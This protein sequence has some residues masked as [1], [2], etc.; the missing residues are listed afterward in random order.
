MAS[1][2]TA[3]RHMSA[4]II[5]VDRLGRVL[6]QHRDDDPA[7]MFPGHWG[8]TGG[9]A[10]SGETPEETARREVREET[11]LDLERFEP[12]RAYYLTAARGRA[13]K[14]DDRAVYL[15]H[16]PCRTPAEELL[17]GEGRALRFFA[18]DELTDVPIAYNHRD[19]LTD[20]FASP[21]YGAYVSGAAFAHEDADPVEAF[22]RA[23]DAGE[24]WF[25]ALMQAIAV[26]ERP[27]E[28]V[29]GHR[30]EYLVGGEAFDWLLL[31]QR[32]LDAAGERI[33]VDAAAR[34][35]FHAAPPDGDGRAIEDARLQQ[36]IGDAKHRAHLNYVYG[37]TVEEAL[38]YA[39]ELDVAKERA[40]LAVRNRWEDGDEPDPVYQRIY[41][42]TRASLLADFREERG[43]PPRG[44]IALDELREFHYWL[45]KYRVKH[46]EPARVASDTRKAL[47]QLS[48]IEDAARR[49][50]RLSEVGHR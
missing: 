23:L 19:V 11:G 43:A 42:R 8:I 24:P 6:L 50:T 29:G 12:F 37:V 34:L 28:D 49:A 22:L 36:L 18:P 9:A 33:P 47:A 27:A 1:Q 32:L 38:H 7:I 35:L 20:F 41:G 2:R 48:A 44:R 26:W 15:F 30:Y 3:A 13:A 40:N 5:L 25:E 31:A 16:A 4:G 45:F 39:V 10:H 17:C 21:A 14:S 46:A